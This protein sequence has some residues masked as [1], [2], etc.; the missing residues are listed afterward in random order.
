MS[1]QLTAKKKSAQARASGS[2]G[3]A[4]PDDA[5]RRQVAE[6]A[7]RTFYEENRESIDSYNVYVE[8]HGTVGSRHGLRRD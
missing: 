1:A 8:K 5:A 7:A 2:G 3:P 4:A 6:R